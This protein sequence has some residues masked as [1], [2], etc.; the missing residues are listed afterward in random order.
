MDKNNEIRIGVVNTELIDGTTGP[1]TVVTIT[2][3]EALPPK[4]QMLLTS[5]LTP[6]LREFGRLLKTKEAAY[7]TAKEVMKLWN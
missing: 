7:N 3:S 4:T 6:A 1:Q 5:I 2:F